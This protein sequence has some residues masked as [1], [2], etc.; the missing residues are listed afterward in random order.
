MFI[1][2]VNLLDLG[3]DIMLVILGNIDLFEGVVVVIIVID[4]NGDM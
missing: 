3:N 2:I 1:V 4:S